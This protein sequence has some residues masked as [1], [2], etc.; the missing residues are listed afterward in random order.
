MRFSALR[1]MKLPQQLGVGFGLMLLCM[2]LTLGA[3]LAAS[4]QQQAITHHLIYHLYPARWQAHEI[5]KLTLAIDDDVARYLLSHIPGQQADLLN[6]YQQEARDL[7]VAVASATSLTDTAEQRAILADFIQSFFGTGGYY[8]SNQEVFN[9]TQASQAVTANEVYATSPFLATAHQDMQT[10]IDVVEVEIKQEEANE[11]GIT[12]LVQ[13]LNIG[14]GGSTTL[15]GI[16]IALLF[17]RSIGRLYRQIEEKNVRLAENNTHLQSLATTDPLTGLSNHRAYQEALQ[18]TMKHVLQSGEPAALVLVNVDEL[19][20]VNDAHGHLYGD[21]VLVELAGALASF[22]TGAAFRLSGDE[23][24][25]VLPNTSLSQAR[26]SCEQVRKEVARRL[27]GPTISIGLAITTQEEHEVDLLREQADAALREAKK[28]GRNTLVSFD[29][30]RASTSMLAPA[31]VQAFRRLL[32]EQQVTVAFQPIWSMKQGTVLAFE[33]LTRPAPAYGFNGP[34][35]AFDI[36][37]KL[38]HAHELDAICV[39]AILKRAHELPE[40]VLLFLNLTPQSLAHDLLTGAV[41]L[42]AV[43]EAGLTVDRVVLELTERSTLPIA[44]VVQHARELQALGFRLALDDAGAGN[45]GL[46]MMSQLAVDFIK[47]DRAVVVNAMTDKAAQGVLAGIAAIA[48]EME[49]LV[50]A[51]GIENVAMLELVEHHG[52]QAVQGYLLGRPNETIPD[53]DSLQALSP[54]AL[55]S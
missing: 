37:E 10:Y 22:G 55:V 39:R 41:L 32:A 27:L 23:F 5:I 33:A 36:A 24:A 48:R 43:I 28:Q 52:L 47:I 35:E 34:Q 9:L 20:D 54:L 6:T 31:K 21:H 38:G 46:E 44:V 13:F 18:L 1:P 16:G 4:S 17:T 19:K 26:V 8:A 3:N 11:N 25:L 49:A 14:L 30:I 15:F 53:L 50:I 12:R 45:A 2:V 29:E 51:E 40:G 7:R 42:E